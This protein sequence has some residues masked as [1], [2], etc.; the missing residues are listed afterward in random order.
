VTYAQHWDGSKWRAVDADP[1]LFTSGANAVDARAADDVWIVGD[2]QKSAAGALIA[3]AEHWDGDHWRMV[4]T[5]KVDPGCDAVLSDVAAVAADDV[6]AAGMLNCDTSKALME[7]WNGTRWSRV[8]VPLPARASYTG[9]DGITAIAPDDIW[10]VGFS[11]RGGGPGSTMTLHWDG[12]RWSVVPSPNPGDATCDHALAGVSGSGTG[13]VWAAGSLSCSD[14]VTPE[15]LH[16]D[17][18]NWSATPIPAS[19]FDD[20]PGDGLF[21]VVAIT[22]RSAVTIGI[23]KTRGASVEAG[24]IEHWNGRHWSLD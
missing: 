19:G 13:D 6:W 15:M 21:D 20:P 7:H 9:L 16:W 11:S 24:F 17:G 14:S 10:A 2:A 4:P 1:G 18:A 3:L 22:K 8:K 12:S 23:A 5:A